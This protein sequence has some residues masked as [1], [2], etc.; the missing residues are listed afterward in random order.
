MEKRRVVDVACP[1]RIDSVAESQRTDHDLA[2]LPFF[3]R[4]SIWWP[5]PVASLAHGI[6][7]PRQCR[8]RFRTPV[9]PPPPGAFQGRIFQNHVAQQFLC[10]FLTFGMM[11]THSRLGGT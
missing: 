11:H 3:P 7:D 1:M 5:W 6:G 4:T 2:A 10:G 8:S 9:A